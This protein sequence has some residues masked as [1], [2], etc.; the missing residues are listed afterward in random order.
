MSVVYSPFFTWSLPQESN[1]FD[2]LCNVKKIIKKDFWW[3]GYVLD[4]LSPHEFCWDFPLHQPVGDNWLVQIT[5]SKQDIHTKDCEARPPPGVCDLCGHRQVCSQ[6]GPVLPLMLCCPCLKNP[7]ILWGPTGTH[8]FLLWWALQI[9]KLIFLWS[10][11]TLMSKYNLQ[12][13]AVLGLSAPSFL[14]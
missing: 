4:S 3:L 8:I 6:K 2:L 9:M 11:N 14:L 13:H 5:S 7:N 1:F 10:V 12:D